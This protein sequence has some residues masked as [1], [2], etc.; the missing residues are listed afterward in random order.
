MVSGVTVLPHPPLNKHVEPS[1]SWIK[2][3]DINLANYACAK[4]ALMS[5]WGIRK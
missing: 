3:K 5:L 1:S 4:Y 2:L